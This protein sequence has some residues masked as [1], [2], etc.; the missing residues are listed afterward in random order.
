MSGTIL[1]ASG[2][3]VSIPNPCICTA[4]IICVWGGE[5]EWKDTNNKLT[6]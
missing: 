5:W 1:S 3:A 6:I 2:T 4:H